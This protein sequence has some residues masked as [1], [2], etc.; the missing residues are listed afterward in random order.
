VA[1]SKVTKLIP[2]LAHLAAL[3]MTRWLYASAIVTVEAWSLKR[4]IDGWLCASS[5]LDQLLPMR[6]DFRCL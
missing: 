6:H 4:A 1:G 2:S 3:L 5:L